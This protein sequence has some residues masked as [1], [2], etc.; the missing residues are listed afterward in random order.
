MPRQLG[1]FRPRGLHADPLG[2]R[3]RQVLRGAVPLLLEAVEGAV[4]AAQGAVDLWMAGDEDLLLGQVIRRHVASDPLAP[5]RTLGIPYGAADHCTLGRR[6]R[7]DGHHAVA[8]QVHALEVPERAVVPVHEVVVE[9]F[10]R[11][12]EV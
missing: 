9:V 12:G 11:P 4:G 6:K 5:K 8:A 3:N 2:L 7:G 1:V 10:P